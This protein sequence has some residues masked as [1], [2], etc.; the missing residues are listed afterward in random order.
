MRNRTNLLRGV[1]AAAL[2]LGGFAILTPPQAMGADHLD[3]NATKA[4][5][6]ADLADWY[7]WTDADG[8][9]LNLAMTFFP[10][11]DGEAEFSSEVLYAFH[12]N[13]HENLLTAPAK[14]TLITCRFYDGSNVE[15]WA[16]QDGSVGAYLE[17]DASASDGVTNADGSLRM[18]A[19]LR[20]DPF[21]FNL[22]GFLSVAQTVRG[23]VAADP[24]ALG[25]DAN[26]C[27]AGVDDGVRTALVGQL[28]QNA[29]DAMDGAPI[30]DLQGANVMALVLQVDMDLVADGENMV[31][32]TWASTHTFE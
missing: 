12:V 30:D 5:P 3:S 23:V 31:F 9:H 17:G 18:F 7:A 29:P 25:L 21:Y 6:T 4:E 26:G 15:C 8:E 1:L 10:L 14:S 28:A 22:D 24:S 27:P 32:S 16:N 20:N 13:A 2:A 11:I 19:G